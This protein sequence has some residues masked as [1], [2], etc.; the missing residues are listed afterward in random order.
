MRRLMK[1]RVR[2]GPTRVGNCV[3]MI[4]H[5]DCVVVSLDR[6]SKYPAIDS[7]VHTLHNFGR[8]S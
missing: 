7:D 3:V 8:N 4:E 2:K 1:F 5:P 6:V